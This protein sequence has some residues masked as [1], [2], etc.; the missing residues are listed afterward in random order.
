MAG[1]TFLA[2]NKVLAGAYINFTQVAT[3]LL[4]ISDRGIASVA[5]KMNWFNPGEAVEVL[6]EDMINGKSRS[7]L[8][9]TAFD[10]KESL[11]ARLILS[12][13][14]KCLFYPLNTGGAKASAV[15][16]QINITAKKYGTAGNKITIQIAQNKVVKS[17]Y[18]VKTFFSG[19]EVDSQ[20]ITEAKQLVNNDFVVFETSSAESITENAGTPLTSGEDGTVSAASAYP[21]YFKLLRRK[22]WQCMA[23]V[24]DAS[25]ANP[26]AEVFIKDMREN[27]GRGVQCVIQDDADGSHNYE[28]MIVTDQGLTWNG[29]VVSKSLVPA[30]VAG[31]TAG[32]AINQSNTYRLIE[33]CTSV[34]PEYPQSEARDKILAGKFIFTMRQ[35]GNFVVEKD[36]NSYHLYTQGKGYTFGK[37]RAI[38]VMDE[39]RESVRQTWENSYVGRVSNTANKRAVFKGDI[40]QYINKLQQVEAVDTEYNAEENVTVERG[41]KLDAVRAYIYNLPV[42]DSMEILYLT[43]EISA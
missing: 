34:T 17:I 35:D 16:G 32:A 11:T 4:N 6:S 28:G 14:Y 26:L 15:I 29:E 21:D 1:G 13:C 7:S 8:G 25:T 9:Y 39:I 12:Y 33:G 43:V 23:I 24:A 38:R 27:E 37:N 5:M 41:E 18:T 36:I 2:E 42:I 30:L 10:T 19:I 31:L 3:P 40:I 22:P 20:N